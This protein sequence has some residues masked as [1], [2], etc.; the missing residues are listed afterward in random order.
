MHPAKVRLLLTCAQIAPAVLVLTEVAVACTNFYASPS[1]Y[2]AAGTLSPTNSKSLIAAVMLPSLIK[3]LVLSEAGSAAHK[4]HV[5]IFS[6]LVAA[7][8]AMLYAL[9]TANGA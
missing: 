4:C 7:S 3:S 9:L 1:Q 2:F 6:T 8:K 5:F